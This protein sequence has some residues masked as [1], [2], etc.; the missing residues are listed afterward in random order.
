MKKDKE[1][2]KGGRPS[3]YGPDILKKVRVYID[4]CVDEEKQIVK[5]ENEEKGYVMYENRTVVKLP[6]I[7]GLAYFLEVSRE[8]I[9]DWEK[10]NQEFS[11]IIERLRT[12][13]AM[14]LINNGIS[15]LYNPTITK[16]LLTKHNYREGIESTGKD[17]KP[18][19]PSSVD[20]MSNDQ[21]EHIARGS[22]N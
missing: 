1:K 6:T 3:K 19:I 9:Y 12:K 15:G 5:Q 8:T 13:Q 14:V 2:N 10:N 11:D 16:V 21:L 20:E 4:S 18:L 22:E 7:E 17:G